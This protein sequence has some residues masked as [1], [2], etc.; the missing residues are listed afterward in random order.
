MSS[1]MAGGAM[2]SFSMVLATLKALMVTPPPETD[3]NML[4]GADGV[5]RAAATL[6]LTGICSANESTRILA[7][8][9]TEPDATVM[10]TSE[11]AT[12]AYAAMTAS[13]SV[14][15]AG[16]YS[17]TVPSAIMINCTMYRVSIP[18]PGAPGGDG[19]DGGFAKG[20]GG[21]GGGGEVGGGGGADGGGGAA[22]ES[23]CP[24][25]PVRPV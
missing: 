7:V 2:S 5:P 4:V 21:E 1:G 14:S 10:V 18:T 13:I 25:T 6:E 3:A 8:R 19:G 12:P 16:V 22:Q 11:A 23:T 24:E 9:T 17:S 20:G 15:L